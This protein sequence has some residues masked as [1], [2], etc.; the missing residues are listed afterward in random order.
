MTL[1]MENRISKVVFGSG[2]VIGAYLFDKYFYQTTSHMPYYFAGICISIVAMVTI[3]GI[4]SIA[5][6]L[7]EK[8][9]KQNH[10]PKTRH[11]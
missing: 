10:D 9:D 5:I 11:H 7:K 6:A 1:E 2:I 8:H 4:C 3:Y